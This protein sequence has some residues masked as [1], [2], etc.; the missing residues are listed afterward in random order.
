MLKVIVHDYRQA[1]AALDAAAA[2]GEPVLL[3]SAPGAAAYAG[4]AWFRDLVAQA[5][6]AVPDAQ[7][8]AL[9]D[10][11]GRPGDALAAIRAGVPAIAVA[12]PDA[13]KTRLADMAA[14]A[15][16]RIAGY[17][18]AGALDLADHGDPR[19]ACAEWLESRPPG[20]AGVANPTGVG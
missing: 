13:V 19:R 14:Q 9:L 7:A 6:A 20:A 3:M 8:D 2:A 16:V 12:L 11:A 4:P 10:C 17:D 5:Q 1:V 18:P 15:G